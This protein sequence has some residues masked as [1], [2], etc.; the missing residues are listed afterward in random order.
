MDDLDARFLAPD[1]RYLERGAALR[2][3]GWRR[4]PASHGR[5]S[6]RAAPLPLLR[7]P[8]VID[9]SQYAR[10][11][12]RSGIPRVVRALITA[13]AAG[14]YV[15]VVW[16]R[17]ALCPVEVDA[18]GE[19][20]FPRETWRRGPG[21]PLA[22]RLHRLLRRTRAGSAVANLLGLI[23]IAWIAALATEVSER[24]GARRRTRARLN[25]ILDGAE[26]VVPEVPR[27]ND[28]ETLLTFLANGG[29]LTLRLF[30]HDLLPIT[31]PDL[32]DRSAVNDHVNL[33]RIAHASQ[34][35][36]TSSSLLT[37]QVERTLVG[38]FGDAPPVRTAELPVT[39]I[40]RPVPRGPELLRPMILFI[41][42]F[43]ARKGIGRL[44]AAL[45]TRDGWPFDVVVLGEP[46]HHRV[47][48]VRAALSAATSPA[49]RISRQVSDQR[50]AELLGLASA[51][52][53]LSAAEGY[54]LPVLEALS[55]GT[56]VI[57]SDTPINRVFADRYGG[58]ILLPV[59][60]RGVDVEALRDA[61]GS[62]R[63]RDIDPRSIRTT[64][65]PDDAEAWARTVLGGPA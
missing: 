37:S 14:T 15:P 44:L 8:R 4:S 24:R 25:I 23:G 36:I 58:I 65:I 22:E 31:H 59:H 46:R 1:G 42:G 35:V 47:D 61:L 62:E 34:D 57:C 29:T 12:R 30:V 5:S 9:V 51:V 33:L 11:G 39:G 32:F 55:V 48:E 21:T 10:R 63:W 43:E 26:L 45:G 17:G 28:S 60:G 40:P 52:L 38:L 19:V 50:L 16:D 7:V 53:Y 2:D 54:G 18:D 27:L 6:G 3:I 56:P 64:A 13:D 20:R 41:G 49:I